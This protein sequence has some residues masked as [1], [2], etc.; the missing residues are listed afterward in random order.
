MCLI[1][2]PHFCA[3]HHHTFVPHLFC[4]CCF[5][6]IMRYKIM[7]SKFAA[8]FFQ[9]FRRGAS[10]VQT[11]NQKRN[12]DI[13]N[14][15]QSKHSTFSANFFIIKKKDAAIT[16]SILYPMPYVSKLHWIRKDHWA[17]S[18]Y[19]RGRFVVPISWV[20][21]GRY[22]PLLLQDTLLL[23]LHAPQHCPSYIGTAG[24]TIRYFFAPPEP[25]RK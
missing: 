10:K 23:V 4:R 25:Y 15:I 1:S 9:L 22:L 5:C 17:A 12:T 24:I 14:P 3:F 7:F 19:K 2:S 20:L 6:A 16:P 11:S 18:Q 21:G 8:Y 13:P